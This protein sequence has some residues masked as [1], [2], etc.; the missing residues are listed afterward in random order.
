MNAV[1][2]TLSWPFL[3]Q[4]DS[5]EIGQRLSYDTVYASAIIR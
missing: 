2:P 4:V 3:L 5:I 1:L